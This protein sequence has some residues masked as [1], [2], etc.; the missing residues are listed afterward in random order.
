MEVIVPSIVSWVVNVPTVGEVPLAADPKYA[1]P[2]NVSE[3]ETAL[4]ET[5]VRV[6]GDIIGPMFGVHTLP[7]VLLVHAAAD[8]I[9]GKTLV[10]L[11]V[12]R[13]AAVLKVANPA[14]LVGPTTGG[15]TF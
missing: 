1:S 10:K 12:M 6:K 13:P 9:P 3:M 8:P 2:F 15:V 11:K 7:I 5:C 4:A 14:M